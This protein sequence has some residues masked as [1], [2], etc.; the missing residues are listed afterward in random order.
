MAPQVLATCRNRAALTWANEIPVASAPPELLRTIVCGA[1]TVPTVMLPNESIVGTAER[2]GV[3]TGAPNPF[4][5]T[6][7]AA[8]PATVN[9]S[10]PLSAPDPVGVYVTFRLQDVSAASE[11]PHVFALT[12]NSEALLLV[13]V[14]PLAA[15]PPPLATVTV[16][17]LLA[18][19]RVTVPNSKDPGETESDAAG[20]GVPVP[21]IETGSVLPPP[22]IV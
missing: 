14:S 22:V 16:C 4:M 5:A 2:F 20:N 12:T 8:P 18:A 17:G 7:I 15:A 13:I 11:D 19:P 1:L 6:W 10:F 21:D 9:V 3:A